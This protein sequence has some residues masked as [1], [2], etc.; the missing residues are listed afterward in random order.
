MAPVV[1]NLF[2]IRS[3]SFF[4]PNIV[5]LGVLPSI[6]E[7]LHKY[8]LFNY[9]ESWFFNSVFPSY[10]QW[11]AVVKPKIKVFE[12]AFVL[13]HPSFD[14]AKSCLELARAQAP[15]PPSFL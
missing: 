14:F 15:P 13:E 4:D 5:S 1:R 10:A 3:Q 9:F 2:Q 6:C 7:A 8:K 11:K 12:S